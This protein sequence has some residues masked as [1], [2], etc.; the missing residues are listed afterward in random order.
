[1][2][3]RGLLAKEL[4]DLVLDRRLLGFLALTSLGCGLVLS[5]LFDD[6]D[7]SPASPYGFLAFIRFGGPLL[8]ALLAL[9]LAADAVAGERARRTLPLL[10]TAP[11]TKSGYATALLASHL[12]AFLAFAATL[13]LAGTIAGWAIGWVAL[14]GTLLL[15]LLMLLPLFVLFESALLALSTR[16]PTGRSALL[17]AGAIVLLA[18]TSSPSGPFGWA[19]PEPAGL[20]SLM[21]WNPFDAAD[22]VAAALVD[23]GTIDW[24]PLGRLALAASGTTLLAVWGF[25]RLE[26]GG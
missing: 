22:A 14:E 23:R 11:A 9:M 4:R 7:T 25:R 15:I 12:L 1:M 20:R 6:L 19:L 13:L 16:M 8:C 26:V 2:S 24:R 21:E 5:S 17:A 10:F 3:F 18:W